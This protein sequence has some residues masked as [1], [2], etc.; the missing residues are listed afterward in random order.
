[1]EDLLDNSNRKISGT[2]LKFRRYL[3]SEI[4]WKN[5]L[6]GIKGARGIG[7]TTL[8]LQ[9][10]KT[11]DLP[12]SK[13]AYIS[14]DELYF[15][16][17]SLLAFGKT[18]FEIGGRL[19]VLDEVHKYPTWSQEIKNLY[20]RYPE[21]QIVFT[22]SSIL[23]ITKKEGDLSRRALFYEMQGLSFREF[24]ELEYDIIFPTISIQNIISEDFSY[25]VFFTDDFRP[26]QYF[27]EYLKSGY[28]PF[29]K[30]NEADYRLQLRQMTRAIVEYDMAEIKGFDVRQAKKIL[31]LLYIIS[32]QVPFKPNL[33]DLAEK[34]GIH[35]NSL[36][37]YLFYLE[38]A[39]LISMLQSKP[40]SVSA[41]QKPEKIFLENTNLLY[42][43][44]EEKPNQGTVREVFVQNQLRKSHEVNQSKSA[45]FLV[46]GKY[47]F[48]VG[49][50]TKKPKQITETPDAWI[51]KDDIEQPVGRSI[52]IWMLG[53]LY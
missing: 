49:G 18:F 32:Q 23:D 17:N 36:N 41:L 19:L 3:H 33:S 7:K 38:E 12:I 42:A 34:T 35:R 44:S 15:T 27:R 47:T 5:P 22:G 16:Q 21:M 13:K 50:K 2:D 28:Y 46:D 43:L 6:I 8:L 1:M 11:S 37:S 30:A 51:I 31:Q 14:L 29:K 53:L 20:D 40:F 25:S 45:D 48:E 26:Y 10:L 24:L 4:S 9:Y 39:R 52:P